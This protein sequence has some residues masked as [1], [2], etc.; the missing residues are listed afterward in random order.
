MCCYNTPI[1]LLETK[2]TVEF[3]FFIFF[4][5]I[6]MYSDDLFRFV[7]IGNAV[8]STL[9]VASIV[10]FIPIFMAKIGNETTEI[11]ML[12]KKFLVNLGHSS[13]KHLL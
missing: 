2:F 11:Q 7:A 12:I 9:T 1:L 6:T 5:K 8:I 10:I 4:R 3:L 13:N